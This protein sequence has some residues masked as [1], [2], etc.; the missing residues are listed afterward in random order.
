MNSV[1]II[2]INHGNDELAREVEASFANV[3]SNPPPGYSF[4]L[5]GENMDFR[6]RRV[7]D[8]YIVAVNHRGMIVGYTFVEEVSKASDIGEMSRLDWFDTINCPRNDAWGSL[9]KAE[10]RSQPGYNSYSGSGSMLH[11]NCIEAFRKGRGIGRRIMQEIKMAGYELVELEAYGSNA[12]R[13]FTKQGFID[14]GITTGDGA[15]R[16]MVWNNP[17]PLFSSVHYQEERSRIVHL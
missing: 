7:G 5:T 8:S 2:E 3:R 12:E 10:L 13:F 16:V 1:Q 14:T 11:L 17:L 9:S 15:K 6:P 4:F